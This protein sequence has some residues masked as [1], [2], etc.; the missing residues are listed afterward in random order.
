MFILFVIYFICIFFIWWSYAGYIFYLLIYYLLRRGFEEDKEGK[1]KN[2]SVSVIV[3]IFN[4]EKLIEKK[5]RNLESLI[6]NG[7]KEFLL[8]DGG[9]TDKTLLI[10]KKLISRKPAFK[11]LQ[12][13]TGKIKQLNYGL[14]KSRGTI[15]VVTDSDAFLSPNTLE[16]LIKE[17]F[18]NKRVGVVGAY[19]LPRTLFKIEREYW[20]EQNQLRL[21]ESRVYSSSIVVAPCYAFRRALIKK[22]PDDCVA[23]DVYLSFYAQSRGFMVKYIPQALVYELRGPKNIHEFFTHKFRKANAYILELLRFCYLFNKFN[24]RFRIIFLSR[25]LQVIIL[26]WILILF[27]AISINIFVVNNPYRLV[28]SLVFL[29]LLLS[30][31]LAAILFNYQIFAIKLPGNKT[32]I[33]NFKIFLY[34]NFVLL[35]AIFTYFF[36]NQGSSYQKI[37]I[38]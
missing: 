5:I 22:F 2:P 37:K 30:L 18:K 20:Q 33:F 34:S 23:D 10:I 12:T 8:V 13:E 38:Q 36:Y 16:F 27:L 25:F 15:I 1:F 17:F 28:V 21:I 7:K 9:S 35:L 3:P 26:P 11:L 6:Y 19:V 29:F 14:S 4:E 31:F 24:F 32:K